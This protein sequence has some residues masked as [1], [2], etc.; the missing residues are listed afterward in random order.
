MKADLLVKNEK[1]LPGSKSIL[2]DTQTIL[3][4]W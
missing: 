2:V 3:L 4:D 1:A